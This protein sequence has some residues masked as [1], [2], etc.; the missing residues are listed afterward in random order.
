MDQGLP[1]ARE[2]K[3]GWYPDQQGRHELRYWDG[4]T[5]T[6]E[7]ADGD[8][9]TTELLDWDS[10]EMHP[11]ERRQRGRDVEAYS[12]PERVA[13]VFGPVT[14]PI[15]GL[16][17]KKVVGEQYH[18]AELEAA[19]AGQRGP[20]GVWIEKLAELRPEPD[21]PHDPNAVMVLIDGHHVG[22]L[23]AKSVQQSRRLIDRAIA[24]HGAAT[25][26]AVINKGWSDD[27]GVKG[28]YGVR[29]YYGTIKATS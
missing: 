6:D 21:N 17:T 25:C 16:R 27:P 15:S 1:Y 14:M 28:E 29:L 19:A 4:R 12:D 20:R 11:Y 24:E 3:A 2:R 9:V 22:Y 7:V 18:E 26:P 8:M 23:P 5:W 13:R 10:D